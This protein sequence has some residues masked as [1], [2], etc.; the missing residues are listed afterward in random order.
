V[1]LAGNENPLGPSPH[2]QAAVAAAVAGVHRYADNDAHALRAR[3]S[4][5]HGVH[6]DEIAFGH[7][8][9]ALIE[10][11]ARTFAGPDDHAII[12]FPSFSCYAASLAA[13]NV[14]T[15]MVP[16]RD[17]LF[18]DL[19]ALR[20]AV[21]PETKLVFLDNPGNPTSTVIAGD[22][23][24][25]L[26]RDLPQ[27]IVVVVDEAYADYADHESYVSAL[28][29]RDQRERLIVLRTFSKAYALAGLRIGYAIAPREI[30]AHLRAMHVPF[31]VNG[32]GQV[33]A[34][35]ALG[36]HAHLQRSLELNAHERS[37]MAAGLQALGLYVAP[38]QAYFLLVAL[39]HQSADV[40]RAL[41]ARKV[42]VRLPGPP[43]LQHLRISVGLPEENDR[44]LL[45]LARVL[46]QLA[47][48]A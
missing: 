20:A 3:L 5:M 22:D 24:R 27:D 29:M 38:S 6:G 32:L 26:L 47:P 17:G 1:N 41:L 31:N 44:L 23:L 36:D 35:A 14:A 43:L 21:R 39:E 48:L 30:V 10:L 15:T 13:A 34:L 11:S 7:G 8:S 9:N 37:R 40:Y 16:L 4:A 45:E 19:S 42:T 18:W 28:R 25:S 12:G 33:A 46:A 2:V